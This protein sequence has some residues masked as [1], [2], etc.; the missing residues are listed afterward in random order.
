MRSSIGK[1]KK[2]RSRARNVVAVKVRAFAL[3]I[4]VLPFE[5]IIP[6]NG[7]A[8]TW[9]VGEDRLPHRHE[10]L[11]RL[12]VDQVLGG[13]NINWRLT[14]GNGVSR[15]E[16]ALPPEQHAAPDLQLERLTI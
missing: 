14:A 16:Q 4:V 12:R 1:R 13:H 10:D 5:L 2:A 9:L 15:E 7:G 11:L 6:L 8:G 3:E